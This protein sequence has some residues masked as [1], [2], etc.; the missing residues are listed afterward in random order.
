[1]TYYNQTYNE[2]YTTLNKSNVI[3]PVLVGGEKIGGHCI[4][5]NSYILKEH[6]N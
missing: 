4:I 1:M 6:F 5:P 2:E 3:R